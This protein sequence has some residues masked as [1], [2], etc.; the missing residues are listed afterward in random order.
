[1]GPKTVFFIFKKT[2]SY[3]KC[4]IGWVCWIGETGSIDRIDSAVTSLHLNSVLMRSNTNQPVHQR[5]TRENWNYRALHYLAT[6]FPH[7][8]PII[9][10]LYQTWLIKLV[11][12]I[13]KGN[14]VFLVLARCLP[15]FSYSF[16]FILY[17][18]AKI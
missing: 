8:R 17:S 15:F 13:A 11:P 7:R 18:R 4:Q 16:F 14:Y 12:E 3:T 6:W 10:K 9:S 1:M 2:N 5:Y